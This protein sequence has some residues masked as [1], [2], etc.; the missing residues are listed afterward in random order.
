MH[1]PFEQM[2]PVQHSN[3]LLQ[4]SPFGRHSS[5]HWLSTQCF[6]P[7]Q[8]ALVAQTPSSMGLQPQWL[9]EHP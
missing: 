6:R 9:L 2:L 3:A 4:T 7:Q 5:L 8:S 1:V